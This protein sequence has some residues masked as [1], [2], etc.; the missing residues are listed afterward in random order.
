MALLNIRLGLKPELK[1][2]LDDFLKLVFIF[3]VFHYLMTQSKVSNM[4]MTGGLFNDNFMYTILY[5][6]I[7]IFTYHLLF[8]KLIH[9]E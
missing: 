8:K 5:A 7:A 2:L 3:M 6:S 1:N 4:G 9:I